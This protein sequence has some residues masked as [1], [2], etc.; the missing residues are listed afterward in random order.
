[1]AKVSGS[2]LHDGTRV[3]DAMDMFRSIM[4]INGMERYTVK[5]WGREI[6]IPIL[7]DPEAWLGLFMLRSDEM[8]ISLLGHR[9][10][11]AAY[12][13]DQECIEGFRPVNFQD[14]KQDSAA[15]DTYKKY[16]VAEDA[17]VPYSLRFMIC[18]MAM[19]RSL[20]I[21]GTEVS[22]KPYVRVLSDDVFGHG[23]ILPMIDQGKIYAGLLSSLTRKM[24]LNLQHELAKA[25][26]M[27]LG[28][29]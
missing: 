25:S 27:D 7:I 22:S 5:G 6:T 12:V 2:R 14:V 29:N 19:M 3:Q 1:M 20:H 26:D 16:Q 8:C 4:F 11:N 23:D 13:G 18:K 28:H 21:E 10:W 24:N 15:L 17:G 9:M